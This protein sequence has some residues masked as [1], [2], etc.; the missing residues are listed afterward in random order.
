MTEETRAERNGAQDIYRDGEV[1]GDADLNA[2]DAKDETAAD[3]AVKDIAESVKLDSDGQLPPGAP[4][5]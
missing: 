5:P 1:P 3:E 2:P 4:L